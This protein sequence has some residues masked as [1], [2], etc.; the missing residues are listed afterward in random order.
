ML[1]VIVKSVLIIVAVAAERLIF[2][3]SFAPNFWAVI[4]VKPLV[5]PIVAANNKKNNG[6]VAP[7]AAKE[8]TPSNRPTII[9]SDILYNC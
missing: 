3:K 7:T 2:S 1:K 8:L 4:T 9:I 6:P 5:K